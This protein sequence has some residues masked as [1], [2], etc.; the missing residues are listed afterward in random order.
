V[1][2]GRMAAAAAL[3]AARCFCCS[4]FQADRHLSAVTSGST[5]PTTAATASQSVCACSP[6]AASSA[7]AD[8]VCSRMPSCSFSS[9]TGVQVTVVAR[10]AARRAASAAATCCGVSTSG[11]G[12]SLGLLVCTDS[13]ITVGASPKRRRG[14]GAALAPTRPG[15]AEAES[16]ITDAGECMAAESTDACE[17]QS[18]FARDSGNGAVDD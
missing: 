7:M 8:C 16:D 4:R 14:A 2:L 10:R 5:A 11:N 6:L 12:G 17:A 3:A 1:T 15:A 9:S 18:E 13:R